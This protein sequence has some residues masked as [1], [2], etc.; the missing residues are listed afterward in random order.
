MGLAFA[1]KGKASHSTFWTEVE[2]PFLA[3]TLV[4]T[5]FVIWIKW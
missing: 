2:L 4:G 3:V 1:S 5:Q